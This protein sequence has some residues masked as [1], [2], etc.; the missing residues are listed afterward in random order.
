MIATFLIATALAAPAQIEDTVEGIDDG[1]VAFEFP[2]NESRQGPCCWHGD[3]EGGGSVVACTLDGRNRGVSFGDRATS[4]SSTAVAYARIRDR[5]PVELQVYNA[6]CPVNTGTANV[7]WVDVPPAA[8]FDWLSSQTRAQRKDLWQHA[9]VATALHE[10]D[11]AADHLH[12]LALS[13]THDRGEQA[14]FWLGEAR[15]EDGYE[16]LVALL[17]EL[18]KGDR[19]H[20]VN[21]ALSQNDSPHAADQLYR[22]SQSDADDEQRADALFWLAQSNDHDRALQALED[23]LASDDSQAVSQRALLALTQLESEAAAAVLEQAALDHRDGET[24]GQAL[25]WLAQGYP[26]RAAPVIL[27]RLGQSAGSSEM[28]QAVFALSQLPDETATAALL[29][30]VQGEYPREVRKQALFWLSQSDD[31]SALAALAGLLG[32][33]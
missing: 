11:R 3:A 30:V 33:E 14:T 20:R 23:A 4:H 6:A 7:A 1:W 5:E 32:S 28:E 24:R 18:P 27:A 13:D 26:D 29:E 17:A 19:R 22:I 12:D 15:G 10:D 31:P 16:R 9:L 8:S 2:M 25:F 21:F